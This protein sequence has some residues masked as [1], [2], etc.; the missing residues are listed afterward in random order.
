MAYLLTR[1]II[2]GKCYTRKDSQ[3]FPICLHILGRTEIYLIMLA[4]VNTVRSEWVG[5]RQDHTM[6]VVE[7]NYS[8]APQ[9]L[10]NVNRDISTDLI[11][12]QP[13]T[14]DLLSLY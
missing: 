14:N 9:G 2:S 10:S 4:A 11:K 12:K 13:S 1:E 3:C 8:R 6:A 7:Y 5:W